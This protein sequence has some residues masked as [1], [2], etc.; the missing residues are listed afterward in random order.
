MVSSAGDYVMCSAMHL[1]KCQPKW[2]SL[3]VKKKGDVPY[4]SFPSGELERKMWVLQS[5]EEA[6]LAK[7]TKSLRI[8]CHYSALSG[9]LRGQGKLSGVLWFTAIHCVSLLLELLQ[10]HP[11][12]NSQ[13]ETHRERFLGKQITLLPPPP[14]QWEVCILLLWH[15]RCRLLLPCTGKTQR[16]RADWEF[17]CSMLRLANKATLPIPCIWGV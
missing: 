3:E 15:I 6:A 2:L 5:S 11:K 17:E 10:L 12:D 1:G 13:R 8:H 14:F 16:A 4:I 7:D 9:S